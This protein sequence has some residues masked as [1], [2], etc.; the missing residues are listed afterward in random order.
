MEAVLVILHDRPNCWSFGTM[1]RTRRSAEVV[2]SHLEAPAAS[3]V[4]HKGWAAG[5]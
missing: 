1:V 2:D 5:L 4:D 3:A